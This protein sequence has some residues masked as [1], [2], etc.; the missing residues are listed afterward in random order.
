MNQPQAKIGHRHI[1]TND[2][3]SF[4]TS[5]LSTARTAAASSAKRAVATTSC[6]NVP[7]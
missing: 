7:T 5:G 6:L 3:Y 1:S 4:T 2:T